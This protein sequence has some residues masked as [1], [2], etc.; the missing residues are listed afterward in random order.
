MTLSV[1]F[2]H[3]A[4]MVLVSECT[5]LAWRFHSS[6]RSFSWWFHGAS[7][8]LPFGFHGASCWVYVLHGGA[9]SF[10]YYK[11]TLPSW[12]S[13]EL[14]CCFMGTSMLHDFHGASMVP[15]LDFRGASMGRSRCFHGASMG[16]SR[17]TFMVFPS[18]FGASL[19]YCHDAPMVFP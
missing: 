16:D 19:G 7:M 15:P 3:A 1:N 9:L 4:M 2:H 12:A 14:R 6:F 8:V 13:M 10:I 18:C 17:R 5:L 11:F